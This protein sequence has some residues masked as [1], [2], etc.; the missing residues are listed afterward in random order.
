MSAVDDQTTYG[1]ARLSFAS[2]G[3]YRRVRHRAREVRARRDDARSVARVPAGPRHVRPAPGRRR[4]D[5]PG[6]DSAGP[7]DRARSCARWPTSA[8]NTRAG[9]A[10]SR[11]GRTSSFISSSCTT[12][13]PRCVL[14][15][16][17]GLTTREACGNSVRNITGCPYAGVSA[18]ELFDVT[19]YA[20]ALTRFL[21]RHRLSSTLPRKFKI[22]FEG[23]T[24][25]SHRDAAS[26]ISAFT[27]RLGPE[28]RPRLPRHGRRRHGDHGAPRRGSFTSSCRPRRFSASRMR[29]C[30][31]ST[32]R[33]LPAQAAQSHEVH[34]QDAGLDALA[35]GSTTT[36]W[37]ASACAAKC[38]RSRSIRRR[39]NPGPTAARPAAPSA[40]DIVARGSPT[41]R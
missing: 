16:D 15:A 5:A 9:S 30:A 32:L 36:S 33:R 29:C 23:C 3:R 39:T 25:R 17:S 21:L 31:C 20:E 14:L 41:A 11:R 37:P 6:E 34:D 4:A 27:A 19:P 1:R 40:G 26:T 13:S 38:R 2:A 10:T 18:D 12:S 35:R 28:R 22:A 24:G 7:A 8:R